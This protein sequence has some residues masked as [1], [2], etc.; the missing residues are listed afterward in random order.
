MK[1]KP[2]D[3][4]SFL[5]VWQISQHASGDG[6]QCNGRITEDAEQ[7]NSAGTAG[8]FLTTIL[9]KLKNFL[10][11]SFYVNLHLTGL[12][13]RLAVYP[14]PLLRTYLLDH[15]L[16]LQPNVPSLYQVRLQKSSIIFLT[17]VP[18]FFQII[19]SLKQ[20]IDEYMLQKADYVN[21]I[22][23]AR[24]FLLE[25]ETRLVNARRTA[26]EKSSTTVVHAT[27]T[28]DPFQRNGPKRRSLNLSSISNMFGRRHSHVETNMQMLMPMEEA[29]Q[30]QLYPKFTEAQH[31]ALCAVLLDEWIKE[32]AA[33][34]QEH[35]IAQLA[36]ILK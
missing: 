23:Y 30:S 10:S 2:D 32:L 8:P 31:V 21:L 14:Q 34:A 12:I 16:V 27:D 5:P 11:N 25:R 3:E 13:S 33:L 26:V 35:T 17:A 15:S 19:G 22:R 28:N 18:L 24:N 9:E 20:K 29:Q 36:T 4:K 6:K 7:L 1:I